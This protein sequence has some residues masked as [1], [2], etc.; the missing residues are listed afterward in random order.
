MLATIWDR[1]AKPKDGQ[2]KQAAFWNSKNTHPRSYSL[3][4]EMD[5][6][7]ERPDEWPEL[8]DEPEPP[9]RHHITMR[10]IYYS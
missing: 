1:T 5:V 3:D 8:S 10:H 9:L 4:D 2:L 7:E 6:N